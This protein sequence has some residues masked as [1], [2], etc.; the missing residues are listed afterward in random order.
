M[1]HMYPFFLILLSIVGILHAEKAHASPEQYLA[2]S[3]EALTCA[4]YNKTIEISESFLTRFINTN[5]C[6]SHTL[7]RHLVNL[8]QSYQA[9]G[10]IKRYQTFCKSLFEKVDSLHQTTKYR[11]F[12]LISLDCK[13]DYY[14]TAAKRHSFSYFGNNSFAI[15]FFDNNL[16][17]LSKEMF[18]S[19]AMLPVWLHIVRADLLAYGGNFDDAGTEIKIATDYCIKFF[20]PEH[21]IHLIPRLANEIL[22]AQQRDWTNA[23]K[24]ALANKAIIEKINVKSKEYYAVS[25]RLLLYYYNIGNFEEAAQYIP[26]ATLR[27][28][29]FSSLPTIINYRTLQGSEVS[30]SPS[31]IFADRDFNLASLTAANVLFNAGNKEEATAKAVKL[32]YTLQKDIANQ[33]S[34]FAFNRADESLKNKVELLVN[35]S[36]SLALKNPNDSLL[37]CISYN[38]GLIYKQLKLSAS[39]LYYNI[40]NRL[41]NQTLSKRLNE[42][43]HSKLL[44]DS[45]TPDKADSLITRI[46]QLESN[47]ERNIKTRSD[48]SL[49]SLTKWDDILK[50]L[51]PG[52]IAIEFF[53][54]ETETGYIYTASVLRND[55]SFPKNIAL[56]ELD[57]ISSL[58][59]SMSSNE[60]YTLLWKP[61]EP[62]LN[63][64]HTIYFSPVAQLNLLPI[65]YAPI[66][67]TQKLNDIYSVYR[68]SSTREILNKS[69]QKPN[70][71]ILLYGGIKYNLEPDELEEINVNNAMRNQS[72]SDYTLEISNEEAKSLRAGI[73]YLPATLFEI[74]SIDSLCYQE[75]IPASKFEGVRA[76]E[77]TIKE[78][79]G[80]RIPILHLATHGFSLSTT[81]R[82]RLG[83]LLDRKDRRLTIEEHYLSRSGLMFAGAANTIGNN[84]K[85]SSMNYDDGIL[86]ALEIS[87][88]D[89]N[90][91]DMVVLSACE[92]GLGKVESD[93][94]I[95]L[96]RGFKIAGVKTLL[97]SL[98]K[99][100]D[101]ATSILMSQFYKNLLSGRPPADALHKTQDFLRTFDNKRFDNPEFWAAF[102]L[103]DAI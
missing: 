52:E 85:N 11:L 73:S 47:L 9:V 30:N 71:G 2:L 18:E 6:T 24:Q 53:I 37:Q 64:I 67:N 44:L 76:T 92:S 103:L 87:R 94:V 77:T 33:Y 66:N 79:S 99:V 8:R 89:L 29:L 60:I 86:T 55:M 35:S 95:G 90:G 54:A 100:D 14:S 7:T 31:S 84:I 72:V 75:G 57:C 98:W 17:N 20:N 22:Y 39:N 62:E 61:L 26:D 36:A 56:C 16:Q 88:L 28:S 65:E 21:P 68:L 5:Y 102:I 48:V 46:S 45:I 34:K 91:V 83:R 32:L 70:D 27:Q 50:A 38:S 43:E 1:N 81:N 12:L 40:L 78:L 74:N 58:K 49:A 19:N 63:N 97:M 13:G 82:T 3:D 59:N 101:E 25:Q 69:I 93:G 10:K 51:H 15:D 23:I 96:Q 42:L 41:G 80:K 4:R